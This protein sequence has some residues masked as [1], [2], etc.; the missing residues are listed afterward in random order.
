LTDNSLSKAQQK[1]V[2]AMKRLFMVAFVLMIHN[3]NQ[4][5]F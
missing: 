4:H 5:E 1:I 3:E 2:S